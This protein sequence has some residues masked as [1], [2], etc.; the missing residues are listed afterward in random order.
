[1]TTIQYKTNIRLATACATLVAIAVLACW[2]RSVQ[3][4]AD[5][6]NVHV[7]NNKVDLG[8]VRTSESR[9]VAFKIE[10]NGLRRLVLNEIRCGCNAPVRRT[11]LIP[12]GKS[13]EVFVALE[14][15]VG[16]G[17]MEKTVSF[18]TNDTTHPRIDLTVIAQVRE[19]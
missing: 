7:T 16:S 10:N 5:C 8:D 1:M 13:E 9:E 19:E 11:I 6:P 14:S 3:V 2:P 17:S 18:A 4:L 12:P 15:G